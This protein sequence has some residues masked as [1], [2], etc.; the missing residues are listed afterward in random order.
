M[1]KI[2]SES[3]YFD[4]FQ[5]LHYIFILSLLAQKGADRLI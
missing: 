1:I 5:V 2:F 3:V 4:H